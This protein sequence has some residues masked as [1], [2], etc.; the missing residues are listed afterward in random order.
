MSGP[1]QF[2]LDHPLSTSLL[3]HSLLLEEASKVR[4]LSCEEGFHLYY[5]PVVYSELGNRRQFTHEFC[6]QIQLIK[7]QERC[8]NTQE[9]PSILEEETWKTEGG[10]A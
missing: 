4:A 7:A 2:S 9:G 5:L 3:A 8:V 1:N 10:M 6:Y